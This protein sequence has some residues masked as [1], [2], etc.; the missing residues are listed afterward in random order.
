MSSDTTT[1][2]VASMDERGLDGEVSAHFGRCPT[3]TLV[4]IEDG[5]IA[6]AEVLENP[7]YQS[8]RP[9]VVPAFVRDTGAE[10]ILAGGMGPM[11]IQLF[12]SF[13]I[14]VVTGS[15]GV[16]SKVVQAW[17]DGSIHGAAPCDHD[18]DHHHLEDHHHA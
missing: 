11:A 13:G 8:H 17:L 10:V 5:A 9:G 14:E 15:I 6:S 1:I 2:A 18:H 16:V 12:E 7:H 3:Y 4:R